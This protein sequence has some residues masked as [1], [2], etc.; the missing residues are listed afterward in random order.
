MNAENG[1]EHRNFSGG[2]KKLREMS[3]TGRPELDK[4]LNSH[5]QPPMESVASDDDEDCGL[6][7]GA[8]F[9]GKHMTLALILK[10]ENRIAPSAGYGTLVGYP[11]HDPSHGIQFIFEGVH[12][13]G[14]D[15][16]EAGF[17]KVSIFG[18]ELENLQHRLCCGIKQRITEGIAGVRKI[19]VKPWTPPEEPERG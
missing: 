10:Y 13:W 4:T 11:F 9:N 3:M 8:A 15:K 6:G 1:G 7:K 14:W 5:G 17:F 16:W 12:C 19:E 2:M 18:H